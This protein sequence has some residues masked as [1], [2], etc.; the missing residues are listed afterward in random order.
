MLCISVHWH[1]FLVMLIVVFAGAYSDIQ[2]CK[3]TSFQYLKP[4]R[5][6]SQAQVW[7]LSW[8]ENKWSTLHIRDATSHMLQADEGHISALKEYVPCGHIH[9][10]SPNLVFKILM[11]QFE[12]SPHLHPGKNVQDDWAH[13]LKMYMQMRA[14]L[15]H[16]QV[17]NKLT[18]GRNNSV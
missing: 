1:L 18:H 5:G 14:T 2:P 9:P 8:K 4:T 10:S 3:Q 16:A 11:W 12:I 7:R 15:E 13:R 17:V 6:R